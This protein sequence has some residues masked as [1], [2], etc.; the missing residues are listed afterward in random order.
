MPEFE[1]SR[2]DSQ[3]WDGEERRG[4]RMPVDYPASYSRGGVKFDATINLGH[5]LTFAGFIIAMFGAWTTLDKRVTVIEER[6]G[7]QSQVDRAQDAKLAESMVMIKEA[8]ADIR[9]NINR[10]TDSR[11]PLP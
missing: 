6:A 8:L 5:I 4:G 11:R 10:I 7:F 2:Q 3:P 9:A 1:N